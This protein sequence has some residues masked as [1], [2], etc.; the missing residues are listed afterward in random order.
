MV[1]PPLAKSGHDKLTPF[2]G[3]RTA[4]RLKTEVKF[5]SNCWD[6]IADD[7]SAKASEPADQRLA[8]DRLI[9]SGKTGV[10]NSVHRNVT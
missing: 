6:K 3:D 1:W 5:A 2:R 7:S 8:T 9:T 4:S 10:R